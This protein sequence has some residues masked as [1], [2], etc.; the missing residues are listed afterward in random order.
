MSEGR[1]DADVDS[2]ERHHVGVYRP[3]P[4]SDENELD[5]DER[6]QVSEKDR[7]ETRTAL[8]E[9]TPDHFP[10]GDENGV[11]GTRWAV[12]DTSKLDEAA[13]KRSRSGATEDEFS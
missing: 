6:Q 5:H 1:K 2:A 9:R 12:P 3:D 7:E 10:L 13:K 11:I 8:K 4:S